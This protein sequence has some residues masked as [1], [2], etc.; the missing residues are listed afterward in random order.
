MYAPVIRRNVLAKL[1]NTLELTLTCSITLVALFGATVLCTEAADSSV[2]QLL[3]SAAEQIQ[4]RD[5][6][7]ARDAV[8]K[9]LQRY[10]S[11]VA[12]WNLLG[13]AEGELREYRPAQ[14]AFL[15]GLAI[16]PGSVP[17][18]ENLGFLYFTQAQYRNA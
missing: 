9:D 13:I 14:D 1:R 5:F 11:S 10:P 17:L 4:H 8:R 12:L 2:D 16:E 15:R 3:R 6:A 7:G 18:N